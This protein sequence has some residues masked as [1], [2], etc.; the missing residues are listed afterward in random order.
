MG[1]VNVSELLAQGLEVQRKRMDVIAQNIANVNTSKTSKGTPY[2]RKISIVAQRSGEFLGIMKSKIAGPEVISVEED[3]KAP[4]RI[5][6]PSH[7][8]ADEN[9]Y[10]FMPNIEVSAE[11][12]EMITA[13][14]AYE[15][16][17]T[18]FN[19]SKDMAQTALRIGT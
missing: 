10:V 15:A 13:T 12:V 14:R 3:K 7:P 8:E 18:A 17:I 11:M 2:Q 4:R 19:A 5:F 16:N 9:G 6:D 1:F